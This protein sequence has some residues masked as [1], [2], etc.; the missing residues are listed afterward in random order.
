MCLASSDAQAPEEASLPSDEMPDWLR[1]L[2]PEGAEV[3]APDVEEEPEGIAD[4]LRER[5]TEAVVAEEAETEAAVLEAVVEAQAEEDVCAIDAGEIP[6]WLT[7]FQPEPS[8]AAE[9][10][11]IAE[12]TDEASPF[13]DAATEAAAPAETDM[14]DERVVAAVAD[15]PDWLSILGFR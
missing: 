6:D 2:Q 12:I 10:S 3:A 1:D 15:V 13:G 8:L 5:Q 4:W 11:G 14:V 9:T 7:A